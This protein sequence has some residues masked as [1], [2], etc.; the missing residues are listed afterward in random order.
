MKSHVDFSKKDKEDVIRYSVDYSQFLLLDD[1]QI[2][3][4]N[5]FYSKSTVVMEDSTVKL[6]IPETE[7][8]FF[9]YR[10][11]YRYSERVRIQNNLADRTYYVVTLLKDDSTRRYTRSVQSFL[12][13]IGDLGGI[14]EILMLISA[15][16]ISP[17][18]EREI[19]AALA[20]ESYQIQKYTKDQSEYY[21]SSRGAL[22]GEFNLTTE[23]SSKSENNSTSSEDHPRELSRESW[24]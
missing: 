2:N 14:I 7:L 1:H 23:S 4:L 16:L 17:L 9:E 21:P 24:V 20:S 18:V 3:H 19:F 5:I 10:S 8:D 15:F 13:Y 6:F 22:T 12:G 11:H